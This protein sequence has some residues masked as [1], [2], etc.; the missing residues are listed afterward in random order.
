MEKKIRGFVY[1]LSNPSFDGILKIGKSDADPEKIRMKELQTTGVPTPFVLEWSCLVLDPLQVEKDVHAKF[2]RERTSANR[3]F[4]KMPIDLPVNYLREHHELLHEAIGPDAMLKLKESAEVKEEREKEKAAAAEQKQETLA[5]EKREEERK[6]RAR[7]EEE[8][9]S[10][11]D[12]KVVAKW[13]EERNRE[14]AQK[15]ERDYWAEIHAEAS[16]INELFHRQ[17]PLNKPEVNL[18]PGVNLEKIYS[19]ALA[20]DKEIDRV[21][22]IIPRLE[23][24]IVP[25]Y[26]R[27]LRSI[28]A[29][30]EQ[31]KWVIPSV[32]KLIDK[33]WPVYY[34]FV[35][36]KLGRSP[37]PDRDTGHL[38]REQMERCSDYDEA[39]AISTRVK[40]M[41]EMTKRRLSIKYY[42]PTTLRRNHIAP[43]FNFVET[44]EDPDLVGAI[45]AVISFRLIDEGRKQRKVAESHAALFD[46]LDPHR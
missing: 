20:V 8:R 22:D 4:F 26:F 34:Q 17:R 33:G 6:E 43:D 39:D 31:D 38:T 45:K 41:I 12:P 15:K 18:K 2:E 40:N 25:E 37:G 35:T 16:V 23:E 5:A 32:E 19:E 7:I 27:G 9:R 1:I 28:L 10:L 42:L 29:E 13:R 14:R 44:L 30:T 21:S 36:E 24:L 11:R 46:T 3:E